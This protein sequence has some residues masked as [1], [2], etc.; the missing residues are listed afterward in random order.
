VTSRPF[1]VNVGVL[2]RGGAHGREEH[3]SGPLPGLA[4]TGS[5]VPDNGEVAIDALL[6]VASG[7]SI[8]VT[9]TVTAPWEGECRRCVG[10][11]RGTLTTTVRELFEDRPDPL[12]TYKLGGD[13][14]DLEP[15]VRD[16]VL[17]EL[18]QAPLC[19]EACAGLCPTCGINRNEGTCTCVT[20]S[21]DPRWAALDALRGGEE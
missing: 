16:A 9:G 10:V 2:R 20:D 12:E 3:R 5:H 6:E 14:L 19:R 18:P 13:Q 11:A 21:T 17:L 1:V 8:L 4:V 15:L 7:T